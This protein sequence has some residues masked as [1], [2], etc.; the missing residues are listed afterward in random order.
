M[1]QLVKEELPY[2]PY[3]QLFLLDLL[4]DGEIAT[5]LNHN[6]FAN[7]TVCPN[8]M[9]DDFTHVEGCSQN[10]WLFVDSEEDSVNS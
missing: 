8:C 4:N 5:Y 10:R 9:V 6:G 1:N 2:L 3:P 7:K